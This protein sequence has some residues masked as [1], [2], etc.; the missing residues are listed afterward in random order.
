MHERCAPRGFAVPGVS[1]ELSGI[2]L[3]RVSHRH[4]SLLDPRLRRTP[5]WRSSPAREDGKSCRAG[6]PGRLSR[7]FFRL[8]IRNGRYLESSSAR[9]LTGCRARVQKHDGAD[10]AEIIDVQLLTILNLMG[11]LNLQSN[12]LRKSCVTI[13]M[14]KVSKSLPWLISSAA[15]PCLTL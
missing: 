10:G 9:N 11:E 7:R 12:R 14:L 4:V 5:V 3:G 6:R 8:D 15:L 2:L 1:P 13:Q